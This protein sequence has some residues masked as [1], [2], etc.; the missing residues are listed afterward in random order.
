[1]RIIK[2]VTEFIVN[3]KERFERTT[4]DVVWEYV[5]AQKDTTLAKIEELTEL[6]K[7]LIKRSIPDARIE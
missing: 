2:R 7:F 6:V 1:M 3:P 5:S 4:D